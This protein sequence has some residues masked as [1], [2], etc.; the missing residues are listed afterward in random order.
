MSTLLH[1]PWRAAP[2]A[3]GW[4]ELANIVRH[5]PTT[6]AT[7]RAQHPDE[8]P[9]DT[10]LALA[11]IAAAQV[12]ATNA[13]TYTLA[14]RW[15]ERPPEEPEPYPVPWAPKS[16]RKRHMGGGGIPVSEFDAWYYAHA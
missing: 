6:S 16:A 12:D 3:Y 10:A 14:R 13:V 9:W 7:W 2:S 4:A 5:L 1:V 15:S 8:A 11:H